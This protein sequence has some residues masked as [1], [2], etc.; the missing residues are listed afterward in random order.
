MASLECR[1]PS[2]WFSQTGS[3]VPFRYCVVFSGCAVVVVVVVIVIVVVAVVKLVVAVL[4]VIAVVP[5][6]VRVV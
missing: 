1:V 2:Y 5:A 6:V 3:V 4:A